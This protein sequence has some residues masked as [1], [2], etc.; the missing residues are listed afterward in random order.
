MQKNKLKIVLLCSYIILLIFYKVYKYTEEDLHKKFVPMKNEQ[1][2]TKSL[3]KATLVYS[4][5]T[6]I[7]ARI[8]LKK[9][10][11]KF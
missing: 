4:V 5:Y 3:V 11:H 6:V 10:I 7:N 9:S 1:V 8:I 2:C